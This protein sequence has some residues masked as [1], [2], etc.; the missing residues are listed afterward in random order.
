MKPKKGKLK[1][2]NEIQKKI[3]LK[4]NY[5]VILALRAHT[6]KNNFSLGEHYNASCGHC[7]TYQAEKSSESKKVRL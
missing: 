7:K 4:N 3:R 5:S 1:S 6:N 2:R